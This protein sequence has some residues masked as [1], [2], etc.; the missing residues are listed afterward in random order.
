MA[1]CFSFSDFQLCTAQTLTLTCAFCTDK[2]FENVG[3]IC[4]KP[5]LKK[6]YVSSEVEKLVMAPLCPSTATFSPYLCPGTHSD[7]LPGDQVA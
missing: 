4:P 6:A 2:I 1:V 5:T 7:P 3:G